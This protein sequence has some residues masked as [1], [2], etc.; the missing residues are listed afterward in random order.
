MIEISSNFKGLYDLEVLTLMEMLVIAHEL[1]ILKN[2]WKQQERNFIAFDEQDASTSDT[3]KIVI[4]N[5]NDK[6][7][8]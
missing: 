7:F 8:I 3:R 4:E 5:K 1:L 2:I 6:A